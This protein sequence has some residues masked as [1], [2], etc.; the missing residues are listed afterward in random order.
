[1]VGLVKALKTNAL[2]GKFLEL[3]STINQQYPIYRKECEDA[4]VKPYGRTKY[5]EIFGAAAFT[6]KKGKSAACDTCV[7]YIFRTLED[8]KRL[9]VD[10]SHCVPEES[11]AQHI[12]N[13]NELH[14]G[15]TMH[16]EG[17]A[18]VTHCSADKDSSSS[19]CA[20]H[21]M[22][23]ALSDP[24]EEKMQEKCEHEHDMDCPSCSS[25]HFLKDAISHMI[26]RVQEEQWVDD[27]QC[28]QWSSQ[29]DDL[30]GLKEGLMRGIAHQMR[31]AR[32]EQFAEDIIRDM[33]YTDYFYRRDYWS[34]LEG[35]QRIDPK[36]ESYGKSKISVHGGC[37]IFKVPPETVK[38]DRSNFPEE[39]VEGQYVHIYP[40]ICCDDSQQ[41]AG[42]D[43]HAHQVCMEI[44]TTLFPHLET[45]YA[46][47]DCGPHFFGTETVLNQREIEGMTGVRVAV[48]C[49]DEG[50]EGTGT[51]DMKCSHAK[52]HG[53]RNVQYDVCDSICAHSK[54][55]SF[56]AGGGVSGCVNVVMDSASINR[57]KLPR[58][59]K[60]I[61]NISK[62][63]VRSFNEDGSVTFHR[64]YKIGEGITVSKAELD[65]LCPPGGMPDP[66]AQWYQPGHEKGELLHWAQKKGTWEQDARERKA[67]KGKA[68]RKRAQGHEK[69]AASEKAEAEKVQSFAQTVVCDACLQVF[70]KHNGAIDRHKRM[71]CGKQLPEPWRMPCIGCGVPGHLTP[72]AKS[73]CTDPTVQYRWGNTS[74]SE[75]KEK[76][77]Q[78]KEEWRQGFKER[79]QLVINFSGDS[80]PEVRRM[81]V[82]CKQSACGGSGS[83]LVEVEVH[84]TREGTCGLSFVSNEQSGQVQVAGIARGSEG[85]EVLTIQPGFS[86]QEWAK[87]E[88]K[89]EGLAWQHVHAVGD[90]ED[91][92]SQLQ[93]GQT[94]RLRMHRAKAP[95]LSMGWGLK[96]N[97]MKYKDMEDEQVQFLISEFERP[98]KAPSAAVHRRMEAHFSAPQQKS[99]VLPKKRIK[100][101][102]SRYVQM[103]KS[104][105]FTKHIAKVRHALHG[106]GITSMVGDARATN[107]AASAGRGGGGGSASAEGATGVEEEGEEG[108]EE[109]E[110]EGRE[111]P[112][113][114]AGFKHM[115]GTAP[116]RMDLVGKRLQYRFEEPCGWVDGVISKKCSSSATGSHND[117][118]LALA[119]G[120]VVMVRLFVS[121]HGLSRRWVMW[122]WDAAAVGASALDI[123][124][125]QAPTGWHIDAAP[126]ALNAEY[127]NGLCDS[128]RRVMYR[129]EAPHDWCE[130]KVKSVVGQAKDNKVK[131]F[132]SS[133][134]KEST[135]KL[136]I[137]R[138]GV[139]GDWV[140]LTRVRKRK[141]TDI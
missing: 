46:V 65:K 49:F 72:E 41:D 120:D 110:E 70:S 123:P 87:V 83:D 43:A 108:E 66:E 29:L 14:R 109:E 89:E 74:E 84:K 34:K 122:E 91:A 128:D 106:G 36:S 25:Y 137:N 99:M 135:S 27:D 37:V 39:A 51:V 30:F 88:E 130:G 24:D 116:V 62:Y 114:K 113:P 64:S 85:Y 141:L 98:G 119:D 125:A 96:P 95:V 16:I 1:V 131:I 21:C 7:D 60:S 71:H 94:L 8:I 124:I 75:R 69:H 80:I 48:H 52:A 102:I 112:D 55:A 90:A 3:K 23:H 12:P 127:M 107:E 32:Q 78:K 11:T 47:S 67:K 19:Q 10:V 40:N 104:G 26:S 20:M 136:N 76:L 56:N 58:G 73:K 50:G 61:P 44:V 140:A 31:H 111:A 126:T 138:Y 57:P 54:C 117:Y 103:V 79:K 42:H 17:G 5:Y 18:F 92:L 2:A 13:L 97:K 139:Q 15:L 86:V 134:S 115:I 35:K 4:G 93:V 105:A 129:W 28:Q 133:D 68:Q 82:V 53:A 121:E 77:Q 100:D 9:Y 81:A 118:E 63:L 33:G 59:R 22:L 6:V 38:I 101:W 45:E 132:Y